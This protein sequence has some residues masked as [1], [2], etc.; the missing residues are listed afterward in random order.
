MIKILTLLEQTLNTAVMSLER[1][2]HLQDSLCG[3]I[4]V[5]LIKV[6]NM[7]EKPLAANII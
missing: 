2:Y 6:G 4:Q 3:L 1:S 7:I 5:I